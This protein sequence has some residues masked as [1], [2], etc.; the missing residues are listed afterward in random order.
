MIRRPPRR[1]PNHH[2]FLPAAS[3]FLIGVV[4]VTLWLS[5]GHVVPADA[6]QH[7]SG[8]GSGTAAVDEEE[9][10]LLHP[11]VDTVPLVIP[12]SVCKDIIALSEY[13]GY[14]MITDSIDFDEDHNEKSQ[15]I[16]IWDKGEAV[17][18]DLYD[19]IQPYL[20]NLRKVVE[21]REQVIGEQVLS[22]L[23]ND[24]PSEKSQPSADWI[25]LRKY[26]PRTQR[27]S[28]KVHTD[29]NVHSISLALNDDYKG[30]GFF[31]VRPPRSSYVEMPTCD[32][33]DGDPETCQI[34]EQEEE[35]DYA[36]H[37]PVLPDHFT[38]YEWLNHHVTHENNGTEVYFPYMPTGSAT[39]INFTVH[40][41][42]APLDPDSTQPRYS[43]LLFYD[44]T[45]EESFFDIDAA[46]AE[47]YGTDTSSEDPSD[48]GDSWEDSGDSGD[49]G[50]SWKDAENR[51]FNE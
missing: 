3:S 13:I 26:G 27:N 15:D 30:G 9:E 37:V 11:W 41:G 49:S 23:F 18:P 4:L 24:G 14:G 50:D 22:D 39:L 36:W 16:Y 43:L 44:M 7:Y 42:V 38:S 10:E 48:S 35:I 17:E 2:Y 8:S 51:H 5:V 34:S 12:P 32:D 31:V 29:S 47:L 33:E 1:A 25:F 21:D 40:H 19:L 20:P 6:A 28:L 45:E 46:R